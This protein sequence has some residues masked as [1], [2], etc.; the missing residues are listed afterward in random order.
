MDAK[1]AKNKFHIS[2]LFANFA[3]QREIK[4]DDL[5]HTVK[6]GIKGVVL[7]YRINVQ[8][9]IFLKM[10]SLDSK[11]FGLHCFDS[12][13]FCIIIEIKFKSNLI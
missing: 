4:V 9:Q 12:V 8:I 1:I 3:T 2:I 6:S 7:E 5:I 13:I 11:R 10:I